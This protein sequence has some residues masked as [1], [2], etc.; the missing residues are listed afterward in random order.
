MTY[1]RSSL[2][3]FASGLAACSGNFFGGHGC[4][5]IYIPS[6]T[7][8]TVQSPGNTWA[9]GAYT[10]V[11]AY[12]GLTVQCSMSI[13][14]AALMSF[15]PF[16]GGCSAE[17]VTW[18]LAPVCKAPTTTCNGAVCSGSVSS[19]DCFAG[20]YRMLFVIGPQVGSDGGSGNPSQ[21][22]L[23]LALGGSELANESVMPMQV[24]S[25]PDGA[26]C[27]TVTEGSALVTL[28]ADGG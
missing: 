4:P 12:D 7:T 20:Q 2:L 11:I 13:T 25:S 19:S 10:A 16:D 6:Q 9:T 3:I 8:I 18:E 21:V 5:S 27:G 15:I 1:L 22:S 28:S 17:N 24:T 26:S 14:D 23:S